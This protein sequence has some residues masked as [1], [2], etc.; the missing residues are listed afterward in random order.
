MFVDRSAHQLYEEDPEED[1]IDKW[2]QS[3]S[4]FNNISYSPSQPGYYTYR[5]TK[6]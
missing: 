6:G 1:P 2:S 3:K 4:H 5:S